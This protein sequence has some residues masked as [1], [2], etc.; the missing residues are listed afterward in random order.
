M[1]L[2]RRDVLFGLGGSAVGAALTPVPWKLLD[3]VSI[4]TQRR[5]AL[6]LPPRGPVAHRAAA[7]TLCP[8]ACALRVRTVG[9]RPVSVAP[10]AG[11]PLGTG[12]CAIGLTLHHLAYHP[13]R[14]PSPM[15]REGGRLVPVD[16]DAAVAAVAAAAAGC[17]RAGLS[18]MVVDRR[19]GRVDRVLTIPAPNA[20]LRQRLLKRFLEIPGVLPDEEL[21][22]VAEASDGLLPAVLPGGLDLPGQ[23]G[24]VAVRRLAHL[25]LRSSLL[26]DMKKPLAQGGAP[27]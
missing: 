17:G 4:W 18:V 27:R 23:L 1:K 19:P 24:G 2:A 16:R 20:K 14:L 21:E 11:H 10:A 8:G 25:I 3:D 5:A 26:V 9:A 12:A 13:L 15:R 6:P 22:K 7:C